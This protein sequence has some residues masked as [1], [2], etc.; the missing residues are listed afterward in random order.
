M[1]CT[2]YL[3]LYILLKGLLLSKC[4]LR[5]Q[6][7]AGADEG[8]AASPSQEEQVLG[9]RSPK[10][11]RPFVL[12]SHRRGK[13]Q[14]VLSVGT[15]TARSWSGGS[16]E[17]CRATRA[18]KTRADPIQP[19]GDRNDG[20]TAMGIRPWGLASQGP[21]RATRGASRASLQ[22]G[23]ASLGC[24]SPVCQPTNNNRTLWA[25]QPSVKPPQRALASS[26]RVTALGKAD[27][28]TV[29]IRGVS[30]SLYAE[31]HPHL[32]SSRKPSRPPRLH[33]PTHILLS[34]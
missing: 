32:T 9:G 13:F 3:L 16:S 17:A 8:D 24:F 15:K 2:F 11:P 28:H 19:V 12:C 7:W 26:K 14:F 22:T 34:W 27:V 21:A 18:C 29:N 1:I 23:H 25:V 31:M 5:D 33:V 6:T 4:C 30:S 20:K 10:L